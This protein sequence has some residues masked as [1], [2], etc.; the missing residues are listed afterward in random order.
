[1]MTF[2]SFVLTAMEQFYGAAE[3]THR[4]GVRGGVG[5]TEP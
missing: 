4:N 1:M 2:H 3:G 5:N